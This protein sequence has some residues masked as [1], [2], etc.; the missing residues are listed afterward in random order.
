MPCPYIVTIVILYWREM[1]RSPATE[2]AIAV[3][4]VGARHQQIIGK[5]E[6]CNCR[7]A[8]ATAVPRLPVPRRDR[9]GSVTVRAIA[10]VPCLQIG[11]DKQNL[12]CIT[13][14]DCVILF[15]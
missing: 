8:P 15:S 4:N 5:N 11:I 13:E 2:S 10:I 3:E 9:L 6:K 7:R 14:R 1:A 12:T